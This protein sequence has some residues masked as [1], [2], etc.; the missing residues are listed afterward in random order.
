MRTRLRTSAVLAF[1]ASTLMDLGADAVSLVPDFSGPD[2]PVT[3]SPTNVLTRSAGGFTVTAGGF[4][5]NG[6]ALQLYTNNDAGDGKGLGFAG[7][8]EHGLS[9]TW[10]GSAAAN[11]I[12]IDVGQFY[13]STP[14]HRSSR[15]A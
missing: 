13:R 12:R 10:F 6:T 7:N 4:D 15:G 1:A 5:A 2:G 14:G 9:P 3:T 8:A 11:F